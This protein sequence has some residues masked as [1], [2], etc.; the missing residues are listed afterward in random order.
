M[1]SDIPP[2]H[3]AKPNT[4]LFMKT[5]LQPIQSLSVE[6]LL[7]GTDAHDQGFMAGLAEVLEA[8]TQAPPAGPSSKQIISEGHSNNFGPHLL[9]YSQSSNEPTAPM[10][11]LNQNCT[12]RLSQVLAD[13][14][15]NRTRLEDD[16]AMDV[17]M[18]DC[19]CSRFHENTKELPRTLATP[20]PDCGTIKEGNSERHWLE[21]VEQVARRL[22]IPLWQNWDSGHKLPLPLIASVEPVFATSQSRATAAGT[23]L[24][25]ARTP[26]GVS[27]AGLT[28][29]EDGGTSGPEPYPSLKMHGLDHLSQVEES[30]TDT[31][32]L[33]RHFKTATE[34]LGWVSAGLESFGS[35]ENFPGNKGR[36]T[37]HSGHSLLTWFSLPLLSFWVTHKCNQGRIE[38]D[39]SEIT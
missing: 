24:T 5:P 10:D 28:L 35:L 9:V 16:P 3:P 31:D 25:S 12:Q 29:D 34:N 19:Y 33:E 17:L 23:E 22:T 1:R 2:S 14:S 8:L 15:I 11:P 26:F 4:S 18:R 36:H 37:S 13:C 32:V 7:S 38:W 6:N 21:Q 30:R 27:T 20:R 39:L